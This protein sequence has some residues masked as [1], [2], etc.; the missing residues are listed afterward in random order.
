MRIDQLLWFLRLAKTRTLAQAWVGEGHV[1][2]NGRRVERMHH[3]ISPG[4]VITLPLYGQVAVVE[5]LALPTR[6]G[7]PSEAQECYRR[8]DV[9]PGP[10]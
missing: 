4:D 5:V 6:R 9:P 8:L 1:R 3:A 2:C 10:S 7:P